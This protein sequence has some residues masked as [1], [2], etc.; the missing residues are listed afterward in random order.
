MNSF[1]STYNKEETIYFP[2]E[3]WEMIMKHLNIEKQT[4]NLEKMS[5]IVDLK[6]KLLEEQHHELL[7][8]TIALNEKENE[9]NERSKSL[10]II[11]DRIDHH[12]FSISKILNQLIEEDKQEINSN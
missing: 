4:L 6:E 5:A 10:D 7:E 1:S 9:L 11:A 2:N 3:I 8:R 12:L